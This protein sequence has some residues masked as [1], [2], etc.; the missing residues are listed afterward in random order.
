MRFG[1]GKVN[2]IY[3][4]GIFDRCEYIAVGQPLTQA[5]G[6]EESTNSTGV[7]ENGVIVSS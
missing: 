3:I 2:I 5:F 4:G 7:T 1:V 6:S